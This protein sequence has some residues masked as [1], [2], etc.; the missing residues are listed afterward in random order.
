[1]LG[2]EAWGGRAVCR[3]VTAPRLDA[4]VHI[5]GDETKG[6]HVPARRGRSIHIRTRDLH[7][8]TSTHTRNPH[9]YSYRPSR[10]G[11]VNFS[12][13]VIHDLLWWTESIKLT[14]TGHIQS[15]KFIHTE[16]R[17]KKTGGWCSWGC[18][19]IAYTSESTHRHTHIIM[20]HKQLGWWIEGG[21]KRC[22][23][24][25]RLNFGTSQHS[26]ASTRRGQQAVT[27]GIAAVTREWHGI[28][29]GSRE[30]EE[31]RREGR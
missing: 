9:K 30:G 22:L 3:S 28:G 7:T 29:E 23:S 2:A 6:W 13:F 5:S 18:E 17:V 31:K 24:M 14:Q 15:L 8:D 1:M 25:T 26:T 12:S 27:R 11:R 20:V 16:M 4:Q 10:V 19:H 21:R